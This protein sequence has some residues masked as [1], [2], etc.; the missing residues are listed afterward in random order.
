MFTFLDSI[1]EE[2]KK[3]CEVNGSKPSS[4]SSSSS[5]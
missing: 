3:D 1:R 4:S 5:S 2:K